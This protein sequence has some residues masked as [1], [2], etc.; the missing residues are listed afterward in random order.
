MEFARRLR[1]AWQG[2]SYLKRAAK[3]PKIRSERIV[4]LLRLPRS[5][6][7]LSATGDNKS[8]RRQAL[9]QMDESRLFCE[10]AVVLVI[11]LFFVF[12]LRRSFVGEA[13]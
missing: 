1:L 13:I 12:A 11:T 8:C 6:I 3:A 4:V 5:P 9:G 10:D 7:A 2:E